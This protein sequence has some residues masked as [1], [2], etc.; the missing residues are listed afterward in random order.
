MLRNYT[1]Q[2]LPTR[3][4]TSNCRCSFKHG[5]GHFQFPSTGATWAHSSSIQWQRP[6][7]HQSSA[8]SLLPSEGCISE[9]QR[10][11]WAPQSWSS[12][13]QD[14]II[15]AQNSL[16]FL[17][18]LQQGVAANRSVHTQRRKFSFFIKRRR[19][20]GVKDNT[21]RLTMKDTNE[22]RNS[23]QK[24]L[25]ESLCSCFRRNR[26]ALDDKEAKEEPRT[27]FSFFRKRNNIYGPSSSHNK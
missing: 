19:E 26:C 13:Q 27:R 2:G 11:I 25:R 15:S 18:P 5:Q 16:A 4:R 22:E 1:N 20:A 24:T 6:F 23:S 21:V 3:C 14:N 10:Q 9:K 7:Y 17:D 8:G 12:D